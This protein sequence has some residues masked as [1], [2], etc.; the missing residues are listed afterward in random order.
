MAEYCDENSLKYFVSKQKD[1]YIPEYRAFMIFIK[2]LDG[3]MALH[4]HNIVHR[5]L[6]PLHVMMNK[7][8]P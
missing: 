8:I 7:G 4:E 6:R 3:M 2:I 5:D 1:Q